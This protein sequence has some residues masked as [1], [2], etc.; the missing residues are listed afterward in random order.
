MKREQEQKG[1]EQEHKQQVV[2]AVG[3]YFEDAWGS[4]EEGL[5]LLD[6]C[7]YMNVDT[8]TIRV[9]SAKYMEMVTSPSSAYDSTPVRMME[10]LLAKPLRMLS[11]NLWPQKRRRRRR[12][13][14]GIA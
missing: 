10:M 9:P 11:A 1:G 4:G 5:G 6:G 3:D 12:R 7:E 8:T 2:L 14:N 13:R